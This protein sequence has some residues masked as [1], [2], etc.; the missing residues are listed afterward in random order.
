MWN[1]AYVI[2]VTLTLASTF[3]AGISQ[4]LLKL[5]AGKEYASWLREYL[6][7]QVI[8]AYAIFVLTTVLSVVA[9]R[10]IPLSLSTAVAATGQVFVPLLSW[11]VLKEHITSKKALGMAAIVVGIVI[12]AL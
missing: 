11:L 4:L 12:F 5:A 2:G 1:N 3:L 6:N 9:L 8:T 7:A 10:F